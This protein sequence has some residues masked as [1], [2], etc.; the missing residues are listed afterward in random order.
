VEET[1]LVERPKNFERPARG[2]YEGRILCSAKIFWCGAIRR[3]HACAWIIKMISQF[4]LLQSNLGPI[5]RSALAMR[6]D[7]PALDDLY[8]LDRVGLNLSSRQRSG[9]KIG[10]Q[11]PNGS[12]RRHELCR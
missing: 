3:L 12:A 6:S 2:H 9:A 11:S 7:T 1:K 8:D 4:N 10:V 5:D